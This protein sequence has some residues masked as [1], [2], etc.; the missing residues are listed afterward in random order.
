M[1]FP[2]LR[3]TVLGSGTSSGVPTLG[4]HCAVCRSADERDKRLRP[5]VLVSW[6][7]FNL[8]I[9]TTPDFRIQA[10][11]AGIEHV[12]AVLYTHSHADHILGLDDVRPFNFKQRGAIPIYASEDTLTDIRRVFRYAF[13]ATPTE[14][15]VPQLETRVFTDQCFDV[16]GLAVTPLRLNH[17]RSTVFGFRIGAFAYLTDHSDIPP[18]TMRQLGGLDVLF[19]DALRHRPHPTH[20][21][22]AKSLETTAALKPN[23]TFFTHISHD[24]GH[25]ATQAA[26]PPGVFLAYDGLEICV[27]G[28]EPLL[29]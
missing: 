8:L 22:V 27:P 10:L 25:A 11:R 24:L 19:L 13:D 9:D 23:R 17:G 4:C 2:E 28:S 29:A 1:N 20:S 14:S 15:S 16:L 5:S 7:G 26:L 18:E 12:D 21:T 3:V 6:S